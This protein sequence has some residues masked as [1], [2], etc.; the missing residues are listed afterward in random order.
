ME[1]VR[2]WSFGGGNGLEGCDGAK[3]EEED[4]EKRGWAGGR[5]GPQV[6]CPGEKRRREEKRGELGCGPV[7]GFYLFF[8]FSRI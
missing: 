4:K 8:S 3:S 6:G 7:P 2:R 1:P 5:D